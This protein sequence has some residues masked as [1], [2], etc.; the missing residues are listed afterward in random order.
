MLNNPPT[1]VN[2]LGV[3]ISAVN[4]SQSVE[5][6][7]D[8]ISCR[9]SHYICVTPAHGVMECYHQPE[10]RRIF[11]S[12]GLTT[13]D[14]MSIVWLLKLKGYK[15]IDRVYG[16]DLMLALCEKSI[17]GGGY[18]HFFYGGLPGVAEKL[19]VKLTDKYPGL[20]IVG[21]YC[22]PFRSLSPEENHEVIDHI[23]SVKPDIVW[24][25]ISTPQKEHWMAE[26]INSINAPVLIGAGAAFD[27]LSGTK[28]QAP[29]L[30]QRMGMEW[31]FRLASEPKRL[32]RRYAEYPLFI[33]LVCAQ[34]L[35]IKQY[36]LDQ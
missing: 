26:H 14:G 19:S 10:L 15:N 30:I 18:R 22:P 28:R 9:E 31:L 12:S 5:I 20:K 21:T 36:P 34:L 3:G 23:N 24:V 17:S 13:P 1:R 29:R 32:W 11:N 4:L 25:G 27:F 6:I 33:I 35:G 8:W 16:P 7:A 2:V